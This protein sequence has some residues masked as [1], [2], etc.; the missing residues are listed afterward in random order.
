MSTY[1]VGYLLTLARQHGTSE[2]EKALQKIFTK[3]GKTVNDDVTDAEI[4]SV[5]T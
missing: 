4:E 3:L 1:N 2:E 5:K